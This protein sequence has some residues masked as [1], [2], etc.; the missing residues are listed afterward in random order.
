MRESSASRSRRNAGPKWRVT[1]APRLKAVA[2]RTRGQFETC[3]Q[4]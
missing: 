4:S 3:T 2:R 1:G